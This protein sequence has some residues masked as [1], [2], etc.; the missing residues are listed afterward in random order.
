[1]NIAQ[2]KNHVLEGLTQW[3]LYKE[4]ITVVSAL[5]TNM[6]FIMVTKLWPQEA[7]LN[8][9]VRESFSEKRHWTSEKVEISI[10]L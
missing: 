10:K 3:K 8:F 1:M 2:S 9:Y 7:N 6:G 5:G 4:E